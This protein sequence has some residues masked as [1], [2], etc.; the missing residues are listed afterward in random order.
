MAAIQDWGCVTIGADAEGALEVVLENSRLRCRYRRVFMGNREEEPPFETFIGEFVNKGTEEDQIKNQGNSHSDLIDAAA[1]RAELKSA[2]I[3]RVEPEEITV[4]ME[5]N[6]AKGRPPIQ[7]ITLYKDRPYLRIDYQEWFVNVVDIGTPGGTHH[8]C[9]EIYGKDRWIR[10]YTY[11]PQM[12][13]DRCPVD[14]GYENMTEIEDPSP[15]DYHGWFIMGIY[16]PENGHGYGRVA[17][18]VAVDVIKLLFGDEKLGR[19]G[20]ELFPCFHRPHQPFTSYIYLVSSG[21]EEVISL[22][23]K[24]AD[25]HPLR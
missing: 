1:W 16:N 8:G 11:Y 9:Y 21:P 24:I 5:W 18:V 2:S 3:L 10:D 14:I 13:F 15:L 7:D 17:P 23:K 25:Q 4:R 6:Y 20:F 12:Y 19:R 22:G